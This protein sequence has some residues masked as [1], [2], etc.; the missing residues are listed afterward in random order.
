MHPIAISILPS[1]GLRQD[2]I[3]SSPEAEATVSL[4]T[5][6]Q[7]EAISET[8]AIACSDN[9]GGQERLVA[10]ESQGA[11]VPNETGLS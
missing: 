5:H 1:Q 8:L 4:E 6:P 3:A 7:D 10:T 11:G 9:K 2:A